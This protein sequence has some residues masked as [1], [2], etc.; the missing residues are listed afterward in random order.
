LVWLSSLALLPEYHCRIN[1]LRQLQYIDSTSTVQ[2]KVALKLFW[3]ISV[4]VSPFF[5]I[6]QEEHGLFVFP[7][8]K[9]FNT[10]GLKLQQVPSISHR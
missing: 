3:F 7:L 6:I 9:W 10:Q 5:L 8:A 1:V 4:T 2:L